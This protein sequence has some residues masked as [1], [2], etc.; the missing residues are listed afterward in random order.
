M[1]TNMASQ[2]WSKTGCGRDYKDAG[3]DEIV[4]A[5]FG[6]KFLKPVASPK[7][8]EIYHIKESI[9]KELM[10]RCWRTGKAKV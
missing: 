8:E 9:D 2:D 10:T 7:K 5:S 6:K 1:D 4:Q 3:K